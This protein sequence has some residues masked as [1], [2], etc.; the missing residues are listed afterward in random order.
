MRSKRRL[1]IGKSWSEMT[2]F[3]TASRVS[4]SWRRL[5]SQC[6][7]EEYQKARIEEEAYQGR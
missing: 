2:L 3:A 7:R 1:G 5:D 6:R 4:T